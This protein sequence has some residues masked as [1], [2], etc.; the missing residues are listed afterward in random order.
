LW[1]GS[2]VC[3]HGPVMVSTGQRV[4][5]WTAHQQRCK[6]KKIYKGKR[7]SLPISSLNTAWGKTDLAT[8]PQKGYFGSL[9]S[10][11]SV[12]TNIY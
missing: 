5:E 9:F 8:E 12:Y 2:Q 3:F 6:K 10:C 7:F 4:T 11:T 1:A